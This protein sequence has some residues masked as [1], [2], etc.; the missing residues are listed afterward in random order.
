MPTLIYLDSIIMQMQYYA[1]TFY[2]MELLEKE[3]FHNVWI[4]KLLCR[5]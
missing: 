5:K 1:N 2:S 3:N 4:L